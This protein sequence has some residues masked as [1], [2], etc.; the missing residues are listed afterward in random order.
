MRFP[1]KRNWTPIN[2]ISSLLAGDIVFTATLDDRNTIQTA[3]AVSDST[4]SVRISEIYGRVNLGDGL[5]TTYGPE[6]L[7]IDLIP[8]D[9]IDY[10]SSRSISNAFET[11]KQREIF[12]IF[13]EI[14]QP[15]CCS[16]DSVR[17][18]ALDLTQRERDGMY[19][20]VV[21]LVEV[22]LSKA[23]SLQGQ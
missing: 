11:M 7:R 2:D 13:D 4:L 8:P 3:Y 9:R 10:R 6:I 18:D 23:K 16:L 19:E 21:K 14:Q 22:R 20:A 1:D 15:D 5:L 17:F 12:P